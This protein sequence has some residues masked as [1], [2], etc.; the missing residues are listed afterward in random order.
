MDGNSCICNVIQLN[1]TSRYC[2]DVAFS[3][4]P[5][6][7]GTHKTTGLDL[8]I[9]HGNVRTFDLIVEMYQENPLRFASDSMLYVWLDDS[10]A[11]S[12]ARNMCVSRQKHWHLP[13]RYS[14][15]YPKSEDYD[16]DSEE[17]MI[18][19]S[20]GRGFERK[21]VF[22]LRNTS[23][24]THY[25][26]CI[27]GIYNPDFANASSV[28]ILRKYWWSKDPERCRFCGY[29]DALSL[30][31]CKA[32][33]WRAWIKRQQDKYASGVQDCPLLDVCH[34]CRHYTHLCTCKP[35]S[36]IV[37]ALKQFAELSPDSESKSYSGSDVES[38]G[39]VPGGDW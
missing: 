20:R 7:K 38:T 35:G 6:L 5:H 32:L 25:S 37:H 11:L 29:P 24:L 33:L 30:C 21:G 23:V 1:Y 9:F 36:E 15:R 28:S 27:A 18:I 16:T 26:F 17:E 31:M 14:E 34:I 2:G 19:T 39:S 4:V 3:M 13:N 22:A 10:S 8:A 12:E